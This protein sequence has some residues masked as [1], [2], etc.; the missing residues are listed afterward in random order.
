M[1]IEFVLSKNGRYDVTV[2]LGKQ[3]EIYFV[4]I[5]NIQKAKKCI[6]DALFEFE[7]TKHFVK[8]ELV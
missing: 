8:I 3:V 4:R 7:A 2:D 1:F 5:S 6:E